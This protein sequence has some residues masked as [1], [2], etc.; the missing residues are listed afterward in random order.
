MQD[1]HV[2]SVFTELE[3]ALQSNRGFER[4]LLTL[5]NEKNLHVSF[6]IDTIIIDI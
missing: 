3:G 2:N 1:Q 5:K 6:Y 4:K